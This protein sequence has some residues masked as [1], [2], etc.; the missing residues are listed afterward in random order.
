MKVNVKNLS[1]TKKKLTIDNTKEEVNHAFNHAIKRI[2]QKATIKGFRKGKIPPQVL[3]QYYGH[4]IHLESLNHLV[5]HY[6]PEAFKE[7]KITPLLRP[8]LDLAPLEKNKA[9]TYHVEIEVKPAIE[10]PDY[11]KVQ[12]NKKKIIID[13]KEITKELIRLQDSKAI[14]KPAPEMTT[15]GDGL[16]A[17]IDFDGTIDGK[18]F[19]GG[20]G[21]GVLL[22]YGKGQ[23][24]KDF[25]SGLKGSKK[26]DSKTID[27]L[28]PEDYFQPELKGE[29]AQFN[30]A[31]KDVHQKELPPLDD[32]L[33]KDMGK[34]T[35]EALKKEISDHLIKQK[36]TTARQEYAKEAM[37]F[38]MKQIKVEV[39]EGLLKM[40]IDQ[41]KKSKEQAEKDICS[42]F[43]LQTIAE[44]ES[45]KVAPQEVEA[46][47]QYLSRLYRQPVNTI[48]QYYS[49]NQLIPQLYAQ[50]T[51]EKT[52]DF[53]VD[54]A[55]LKE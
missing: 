47:F 44:K 35:L 48:K 49:Q 5:D 20:A 19:K 41:N 54:N 37:E 46:R 2:G 51:M 26:G 7:N 32:E 45:I 3:E 24:L 16:V 33:A 50:L 53:V 38:L 12:I 13:E 17:T 39:P 27:V 14:L 4:D 8:K 52:L 1:A 34:E 25:E 43:I 40:E 28:F 9:Y 18:P 15:L 42:Q 23:F 36:E 22:E 31:V 30:V 10:I 55:T 29:K 21:K 6:L 11:K